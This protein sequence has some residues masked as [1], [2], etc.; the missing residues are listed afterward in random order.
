VAQ[1]GKNFSGFGNIDWG[2]VG[3]S[4]VVGGASNAAGSVAGYAASG[5]SFLVNNISSLVLR[6]AVISPFAADAGHIAGGT[7][8]NL[9]A[10]QKFG[11]AFPIRLKGL[12]KIWLS[13]GLWVL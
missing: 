11:E 6:S 9:F 1:T 5:M 2:Q 3:V 12:G 13:V 7:A 4:A 10:G 8:M